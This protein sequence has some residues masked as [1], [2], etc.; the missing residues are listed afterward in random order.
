MPMHRLFADW[1]G[2]VQLNPTPEILDRRW[3]CVEA[4]G[5]G[6]QLPTALNVVRLFLGVSQENKSADG[7][8]DTI[9]KADSTFPVEGNAEL[10][11]VMLG[12][13]AANT[14]TSVSDENIGTAVALALRASQC[15]GI[16]QRVRPESIAAEADQYLVRT[17]IERRKQ[18]LAPPKAPPAVSLLKPAGQVALKRA[19]LAEAADWPV[20]NSNDK[21]LATAIDVAAGGVEAL[22]KTVA[23]L[24][25]ETNAAL[26]ALQESIAQPAL[27]VLQEE[28]EVLWWLFAAR[29]RTRPL[30]VL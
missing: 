14:L 17:G 3:A 2:R 5:S 13:V 29:R 9:K 4:V 7:F 12:A 25:A 1:Y 28:T 11:R 15:Q 20:A 8:V 27:A 21:S 26:V 24:Q 22:R 16:G 10:L 19:T 18:P 6:L 23:T 30:S